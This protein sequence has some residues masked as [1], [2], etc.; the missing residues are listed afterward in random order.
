MEIE[1][2]RKPMSFRGAMFFFFIGLIF[3]LLQTTILTWIAPTGKGPNLNLILVI[4]LGLNAPVTAG[5]ALAASLGLLRDVTGGGTFGLH[6]AIFLVIFLIAGQLRQ[7]L[8]PAGLWHLMPFVLVFSLAAGGL[9]WMSFFLLDL[10]VSS[11]PLTWSSP[12]TSFFISA[13]LTSLLGP[14]LFRFLVFFQPLFGS[15]SE[16]KS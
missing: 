15:R 13:V 1:L 4:Y 8:D 7:R 2:G 16:H 10:Q 3:L 14:L 5:M 6:F 11:A 9:A 12:W